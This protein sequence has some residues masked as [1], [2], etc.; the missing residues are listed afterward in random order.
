MKKDVFLSYS[1]RDANRIEKIVKALEQ[2]GISVWWDRNIPPGKTWDA[3]LGKALAEAKCVVVLWTENSVHSDWV[4]DEAAR[5]KQR[6]ILVPALLDDAEIPLGFGR[7]EA[8]D[9]RNWDGDA[10]DPE[11]A[12]FLAAIRSYIG[13][14]SGTSH[15]GHTGVAPV[16]IWNFRKFKLAY[17]LI[18]ILFFAVYYLALQ[19]S[20]TDSTQIAIELWRVEGDRATE[21]LSSRTFS[22]NAGLDHVE[23]WLVQELKALAPENKTPIKVT[24]HVPADLKSEDVQYSTEPQ[25]ELKTY[26]NV[27]SGR[28]KARPQM[29]LTRKFLGELD[30]G[31][32]IEFTKLGY[33]TVPVKIIPGQEKNKTFILKQKRIAVAVEHFKND[34]KNTA[35]RLQR[36]L[37]KHKQLKVM[38]PDALE[39]LYKEIARVRESFTSN[40]AIQ[41]ATRS[42]LGVDFIIRGALEME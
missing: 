26:V 18:P 25:V 37:S 3:V 6:N 30:K 34:K 29:S 17:L 41:S 13:K 27:A 32:T 14:E 31:F 24:L 2:N 11:F 22:K 21:M 35:T 5:G 23:V 20:N 38:Q 39:T 1:S 42:S 36:K 16:Q 4:K 33:E 8:A 7:I 10:A 28:S 9:L 12:N 19:F 15:V 40:I